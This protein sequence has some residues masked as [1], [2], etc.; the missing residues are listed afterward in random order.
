MKKRSSLAPFSSGLFFASGPCRCITK[1]QK[2]TCISR[3][4]SRT[5]G[6]FP[7]GAASPVPGAQP[8]RGEKRLLLKEWK[9]VCHRL[10][11]WG[12]EWGPPQHTAALSNSGARTQRSLPNPISRSVGF[13]SGQGRLGRTERQKRNTE[14]TAEGQE[15]ATGCLFLGKM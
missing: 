1:G 6:F 9:E 2:T 15:G 11:E 5:P 4:S 3:A 13:L 7:S 14:T 8:T 12:G 10:G